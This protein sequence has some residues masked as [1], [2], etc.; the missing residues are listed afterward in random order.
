M[1]TWQDL[2][3]DM[4]AKMLFLGCALNKG[5]CYVSYDIDV[6]TVILKAREVVNEYD[7]QLYR[8]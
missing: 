5:E 8:E 7:Q 1:I 3:E 6:P 2:S 4:Q